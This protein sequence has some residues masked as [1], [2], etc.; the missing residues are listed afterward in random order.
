MSTRHL[1]FSDPYPSYREMHQHHPVFQDANGTWHLSRYD[2]VKL[3]LSDQRFAR[4]PSA[5]FGFVNTDRQQT[6]LDDVIGRWSLF[7]DPP[8]HTRLREMMS[9]M[10]TPRFIKDLKILI[11]TVTDELVTSLLQQSSVNF[12]QAFAYPLP[13]NLINQ[14]LGTSLDFSILREWSLGFV[15]AM[16]RGSPEDFAAVTPAILAMQNYFLD[17]VSKRE[18]NPGADWISTLI[19]IKNTYQ[20]SNEDIVATCIFLLMAGHETVQ[21]SLGLGL[22]LLLKNPHQFRLLQSNPELVGS[23]VEEILRFESPLN[24]VSRWTRDKITLGAITI[25]ENQLVVGLLNAANRDPLK[26][27]HPD[28]FDITRSNNRHLAFGYGIHNCLGALLARFEL[29]IAFTKLAPHLHRFSLLENQ[30]EWIPNSSLRYLFNLPITI[31][32]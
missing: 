18:T 31:N 26:F 23:A 11:E 28:E 19:E 32:H 10:I 17:L 30:I 9:V 16:D 24:K 22:M 13:V 6:A 12:I 2:D 8:E 21:L 20:L 15:N 27:T 1:Q 4:R 3:M 7:N 29:H 5:N 14:L 25:P